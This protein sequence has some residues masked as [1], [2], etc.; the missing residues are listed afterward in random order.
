[1]DSKMKCHNSCHL[2]QVHCRPGPATPA[3][4]TFLV[5]M[6]EREVKGHR[7]QKEDAEHPHS[8]A[9]IILSN[10]KHTGNLQQ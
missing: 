5:G 6:I 7:Q 2:D 8:N 1:M 4:I 9:N 3:A 10:H